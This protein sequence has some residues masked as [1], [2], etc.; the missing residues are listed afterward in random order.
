M[1]GVLTWRETQRGQ[2]RVK[3]RR[4]NGEGQPVKMEAEAG[5]T[6]LQDKEHRDCLQPTTRSWEEVGEGGF[7]PRA[8]REH[9]PANP[10]ILDR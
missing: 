2:C 10:F 9:D 7:S 5:V 1:A 8:F 3:A 6:C 4:R